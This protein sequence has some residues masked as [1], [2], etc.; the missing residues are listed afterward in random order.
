[1]KT[2]FYYTWLLCLVLLTLMNLGLWYIDMS[3]WH[4]FFAGLTGGC[5]LFWIVVVHPLYMQVPAKNR[6]IAEHCTNRVAKEGEPFCYHHDWSN[7]T[8]A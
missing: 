6:C 7:W 8:E 3:W 1:M 4:L 5:I 2:R